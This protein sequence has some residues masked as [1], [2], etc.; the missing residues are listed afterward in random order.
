VDFNVGRVAS[1]RSEEH[2]VKAPSFNK[3]FSDDDDNVT[4]RMEDSTVLAANR[5]DDVFR[6][7]QMKR[8]RRRR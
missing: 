7:A 2:L 3:I 8:W 4:Q 5:D 1:S 6:G